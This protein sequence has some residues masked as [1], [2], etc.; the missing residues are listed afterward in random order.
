MA[1]PL[2]NDDRRELKLPSKL[3]REFEAACERKGVNPSAVIRELIA[4]II[5]TLDKEAEKPK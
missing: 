4:W 2:Q 1:K 3:N 5:P